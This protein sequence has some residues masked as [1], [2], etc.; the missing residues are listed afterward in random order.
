MMAPDPERS[1]ARYLEAKRTV[2][3]RALNVRVWDRLRTELLVNE[4]DR[5]RPLRVLE[6]GAGVGTMV[7]RLRYAAM[8][9]TCEYTLLDIDPELLDAAQIRL[10]SSPDTHLEFVNAD[11]F[12]YLAAP[13]QQ[14]AWDLI[15]ANAVLDL[16][17]LSRSIPILINGLTPGGLLYSSINY[18]GMTTFAPVIDEWLDTQIER[19]Y[20]RSM[21]RKRPDGTVPVGSRCGRELI[22]ALRE[23]GAQVLEAGSSDWVVYADDTGYHADEGYFLRH[24]LGFVEDELFGHHELDRESFSSWLA[25][26]QFQVRTGELVY[27]AHQIDVLAKRPELDNAVEGS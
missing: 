27:I 3:D 15:V 6:V 24:I 17:D 7:E 12:E 13:E 26:R 11:A 2:D 5:Q 23:I 8:L 10:T 1:F 20:N 22:P 21:H 18:D 19:L 9:G 14:D 16:T 25:T 4:E